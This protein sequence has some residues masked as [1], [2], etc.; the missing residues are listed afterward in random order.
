MKYIPDT[1]LQIYGSDP[2]A[3]PGGPV[4]AAASIEAWIAC[5]WAADIIF[6]RDCV[7]NKDE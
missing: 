1:Q 3:E 4:A 5:R 6:S 2:P 7:E